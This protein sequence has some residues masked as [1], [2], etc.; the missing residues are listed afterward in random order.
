MSKK[1]DLLTPVVGDTVTLHNGT[2]GQ[3]TATSG[4]DRECIVVDGSRSNGWISMDRIREIHQPKPAA[5][6]AEVDE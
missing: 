3:V 1:S 5:T 6:V 4:M 2:V